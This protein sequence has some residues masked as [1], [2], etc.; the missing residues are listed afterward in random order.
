MKKEN[1]VCGKCGSPV[2]RLTPIA[3]PADGI[4]YCEKCINPKETMKTIDRHAFD[5]EHQYQLYLGRVK[6]KEFQMS[7]VQRKEMRQVFMGACGQ[8]IILL[9]DELSKHP[10]DEAVEILKDMLSQLG[11]YFLGKQNKHN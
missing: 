9:R 2:L 11:N 3:C 1:K 8:M 10:D 5:L 7:D 4:L 6:L